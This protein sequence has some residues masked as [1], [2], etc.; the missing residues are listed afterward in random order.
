MPGDVVWA[1]SAFGTPNFL[2][3]RDCPRVTYGVGEHTTQN[4]AER[5][6]SHT[7]ATRVIAIEQAWLERVRRYTIYEY[8]MPE[9]LFELQ[10]EPS[11]HHIARQSITPIGVRAI[12][13]L[14]LELCAHSV[15]LRVLPSLWP[16][17]DQ[18]ADSTL[19]FSI[20]RMSF[21]QPPIAGYVPRISMNA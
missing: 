8:A 17:R 12:P 16:L 4:D 14:L 9:A 6:L 21:A 5:W 19:R 3:P 10:D 11:Q 20:Y 2:L 15:E 7:S 18:I 13:D 1:V